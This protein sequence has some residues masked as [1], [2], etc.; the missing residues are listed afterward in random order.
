MS[1]PSAGIAESPIPGKSGAITVNRSA[2]RGM[3]GLHIREVSAYPCSKITVGPCPAV[4]Y[5]HRTPPPSAVREAI[6]LSSALAPAA[7]NEAKADSSPNVKILTK[8]RKRGS[9]Q[10]SWQE[11]ETK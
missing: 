3:I 6:A 5:C 4:K 1:E 9:M 2:S 10:I 11:S 8:T 7:E